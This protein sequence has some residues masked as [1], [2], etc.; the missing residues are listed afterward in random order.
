MYDFL[1]VEVKTG[2]Q[3]G[4]FTLAHGGLTKKLMNTVVI[5]DINNNI[6]PVATIPLVTDDDRPPFDEPWDYSYV[7]EVLMYLS[8][9]SRS[10]I[11]FVVNQCSRFTHNPSRSHYEA[12][13]MIFCYLVG[14]HGQSFTF[15]PN[16]DMK[17]Y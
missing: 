13:K 8:S 16:S 2:N 1:V 15:D 11:Q 12:V 10:D 4:K 6:T 3:S 17:L 5:L 14:T 7:L 9:N